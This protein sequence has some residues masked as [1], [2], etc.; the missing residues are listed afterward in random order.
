[1]STDSAASSGA[2]HLRM[3]F[4][5]HSDT[6]KSFI[7]GFGVI[8]LVGLLWQACAGRLINEFY[9]GTPLAIIAKIGT[10]ITS[11]YLLPHLLATLE[12][13]G[14]GFVIAAVLGVAS[15][16]V[17]GG[18]TRLDRILSPF[19]YASFAL[20]KVALA[21]LLIV[22]FGVGQ[23]PSLLL[24]TLTA[25]YLVFFNVYTGIRGVSPTLLNTVV[26][27]G[28]GRWTSTLKVRLPAAAPF[29]VL[30]LRQGLIY[31]FHGAVLGEMTA[32][33]KGIG[34]I[35]I[36][37]ATDMDATAVLAGLVVLGVLAYALVRLLDAG[38]RLLPGTIA[39]PEFA[40]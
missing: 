2:R 5:L 28:A 17:I 25:F 11:G 16:L 18:S 13:T 4:H 27:M 19:I 8:V 32:S 35:L 1:M 23:L 20:P 22:W 36:Y 38:C 40:P 33:N 15:A 31:A 12:T 26:L 3:A 37:A 24:A 14:V 39:G 34:Y 10:W 9:I 7:L 29:I 6:A 30:G 21:P